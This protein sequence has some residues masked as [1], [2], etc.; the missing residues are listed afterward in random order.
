MSVENEIVDM[1]RRAVTQLPED[2]I[3]ALEKAYREE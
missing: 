2:V 1:I 3:A